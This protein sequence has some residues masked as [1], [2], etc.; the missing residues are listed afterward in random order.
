MENIIS[1]QQLEQLQ[2]KAKGR[3]VLMAVFAGIV[4][5]LCLVFF[6]WY[7]S[8]DTDLEMIERIAVVIVGPVILASGAAS[9]FYL[10][11]VRKAY[12]SFNGNFKNKYVLST[13]RS[14]EL[15]TDLIYQPQNGL[16]YNEIRNG[17]V[18]A[19]GQEK[20]FHSEDLLTGKYQG[21]QF[22][23]C[24]VETKRL[25]H[26]GKKQE[27]ET[28]FEGQVMHFASFHEMKVS[29]GHLQIFEK[30][31]L[32]NI[33]GWTAQHKVQTED[34]AF[35]QRFQVFES[36]PHNAFYIL[37][38]RMLEQITEFADVVGEQVAITFRGPVM[39]VAI[40]RTR[41]MFNGYVD[42]P[43]EAQ[44]QDILNDVQLLRRAGDLLILEMS[45]MPQ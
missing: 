33:K 44:R 18:V 21:I 42:K 17:A 4:W 39:Y 6:F 30:K 28:I 23:Y 11:F 3:F 24:D 15:F 12:E 16:S 45:S 8:Y 1:D 37:T 43:I 35:N 19:C 32:S 25:V 20:Y 10:L 13:I 2:K 22:H 7:I 34:E 5:L 14:A 27:I 38:P 9:V 29:S 31:F 36:D 41:S 26:R 40:H